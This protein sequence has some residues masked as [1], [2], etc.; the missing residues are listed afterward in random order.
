MLIERNSGRIASIVAVLATLAINPWFAYDP[1]N[2]PK[3]LVVSVGAA[4]MAVTLLFNLKKLFSINKS[5]LL[6]SILFLLSCT[7]SLL[8]NDAPVAQQFFGTWGRSTGYLTYLSFFVVMLFVASF[9]KAE[10]VSIL[11]SLIEKLGYGV[12][13][14]TFLQWADLDPISWSQKLMVATLGNINFMSSFLGLVTCSY[15]VRIFLEK[16]SITSRAFFVFLTLG[17][18]TLITV[19]GSIQGLAVMLAG[20]WLVMALA[21]KSRFGNKSSLYTSLSTL[22]FGFIAFLG[23]AGFGPLSLLKQETVLFRLD[24]WRAGWQMTIKNPFFGIGID[25]YG[26]FYRQYRDLA[27]VERTGPQRVTNTAHNIFLDVSSGSGTVAGL[28]LI[29]IILVTILATA[30]R[31]IAGSLNCDYVAWL[32]IL[33]G[34]IVFCMISINQIGV[35]IW[36]FIAIGT[37]I[38]IDRLE[39]SLKVSVST[40][41]SRSSQ[42][43]RGDKEL[44]KSR[45]QKVALP[46]L[47]LKGGLTL[48]AAIATLV[49]AL[50]PNV[51]DARVLAAVKSNNLNHLISLSDEI[52]VTDFHREVAIR[53]LSESGRGK[54]AIELAKVGA[55]RNPRNWG[56]W[57]ALALNPSASNS[58]R[59][60]AINK[61]LELD[62]NNLAIQEELLPLLENLD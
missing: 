53:K 18:V 27:A 7:I 49:L 16:R 9:S 37:L 12:S 45:K 2:L 5:I 40:S 58:E 38:A 17:N 44:P 54:D 57:V 25:S 50:K 52:G 28:T 59:R 32:A 19:S 61:L 8:R 39:K 13:A 22:T 35:G 20:S 41:T 10:D 4:V 36:G 33:L 56:F 11:R 1:I 48:A 29:L 47:V 62:P 21:V 34:F 6:C 30:R 46:S 42:P 14:Y 3:M 31:L 15:L 26:D 24:Y 43:R 55:S 51:V 60:V 23:T